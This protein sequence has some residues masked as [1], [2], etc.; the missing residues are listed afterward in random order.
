MSL[1]S[2]HLKNKYRNVLHRYAV[3]ILIVGFILTVISLKSYTDVNREWQNYLIESSEVYSL[4]DQLVQLLGY[5]GFI[6]QFKN[7][8]IRKNAT[9]ASAKI[10]KQ[11]QSIKLTLSKL[12][13]YEKYSP[14]SIDT[15]LSTVKEYERKYLLT[16]L[17]VEQSKSTEQIDA[18]VRVDDTAAI[19]ALAM[20]DSKIQQ[21]MLA[22]GKSLTRSFYQALL[23]HI[24][25]IMTFLSLLVFYFFRL[26]EANKKE[27]ALTDQALVA[28]QAKSD[29][30]ANMSHEIRT[31]LNGIMGMLQVLELQL[32]G[33]KR[34]ELVKKAHF[35][36]RSLLS[37]LNDVLDYSKIEA[38]QL[39]IECTRFSIR[40]VVD[41]ISA[42]L[43]HSVN[44]KAIY[45]QIDIVDYVADNWLGDPIRIKQVLLNLASNAVKFTHKG[46]VKIKLSETEIEDETGLSI[47]ISDTGIGMSEMAIEQ[48]FQRFTQADSSITRNY[49][50]TGLGMAIV[51]N[52]LTLMH[53]TI[54]VDSELEKGTVFNVWIP[55]EKAK[56]LTPTNKDK[57]QQP[58]PNLEDYTLLLAED[59]EINRIIVS[60]M[61]A[62]TKVKI[63]NAENGKIA[64]EMFEKVQPDL[65]LMDIQMPEMDG[66]QACSIIREANP[67]V[68][69]VALTANVMQDDVISYSA[70][71]FTDHLGK[72]VEL[73]TLYTKLTEYLTH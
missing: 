55:L 71:G 42:E 29:F 1:S 21:H 44:K 27:Q 34:E 73:T 53:G 50:G 64:V 35:S 5:G 46:G 65:V 32:Q 59:N 66:L 60:E 62:P 37:I 18:L 28:N 51:Q 16:L 52:L 33:D 12:R 15:I 6:H 9:E 68:P 24:M 40:E 72:P 2:A 36:S 22:E 70:K 48:L 47:L 63:V 26:V 38:N 13:S 56:A 11:L 19:A 54:S 20:F 4:H 30:L 67:L 31:P 69:I 43:A 25:S 57:H 61:L 39:T 14:N 17:L 58:P 10:E 3:I 41:A 23:V 8:V 49:G 45:L 7:L